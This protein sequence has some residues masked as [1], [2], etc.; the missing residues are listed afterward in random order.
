MTGLTDNVIRLFLQLIILFGIWRLI[1]PI[2]ERG[3]SQ[4]R[5]KRDIRKNIKQ[6][7]AGALKIRNG[8]YRHLDDLL[9]LVQKGYT[10]GASV[11]RFFILT[12]FYFAGMFLLSFLL[13]RSLPSLINLNNP[14]LQNADNPALK[15][16]WQFPLYLATLTAFVP[17]L[18][19]RYK[20]SVLQA[21]GSYDLLEVVKIYAKYCYLSIDVALQRTSEFLRP[22]N[23][24][25]DPLKS[26]SEGF[27][28]YQTT[29]ELHTE[30]ARFSRAVATTF[31]ENFVF[32]LLN[33]EREGTT[34][35]NASLLDLNQA[36]ETQRE[37][38][39]E[40]K[41]NNRDAVALGLYV[42][43]FTFVACVGSFMW[44][45]SPRV[46]FKLQFQTPPGLIF[47]VAII[48]SF[49]IALILSALLAKPKLDY[50]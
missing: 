31:S 36:M 34:Y 5:R 29:E 41:A 44:L 28:N 19:L 35:L 47:L 37:T 33:A 17:Y 50:M 6:R 45:V 43:L 40:V 27:A 4:A 32:D 49:F 14:F 23:V 8:I 21:K 16:A 11:P 48:S 3:N 42:N 13:I 2:I 46:Y 1:K 22:D 30:A 7:R 18:R 20:Y 9:Y 15:K 12:L 39:M 38:I 26:L 10:P 24:L 25:K